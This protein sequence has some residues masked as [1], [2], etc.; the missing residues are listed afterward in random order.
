[1]KTKLI[2]STYKGQTECWTE[3]PFTPRLNE[4]INVKDI[5][6]VEEIQEITRLARNWSGEKGVVQSVEYRHDDNEFYPE[7]RVLCEDI[8]I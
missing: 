1:M 3:M 5:L 7:I 4:L 2:F 6:L 8:L